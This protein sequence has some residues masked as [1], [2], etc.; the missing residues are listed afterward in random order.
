MTKRVLPDAPNNGAISKYHLH[1]TFP[2]MQPI[3][4]NSIFFLEVDINYDW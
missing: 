4:T 1:P 3:A 2:T